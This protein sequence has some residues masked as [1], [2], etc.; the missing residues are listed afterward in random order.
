MPIALVDCNNF[1]VSCER[2][3]NPK[4]EG[5]PVVVLSNNDGCAVAR[6]NEVKALGIKMGEPWFRMKDIAKQ[7]GI[8]A[9][10]SNYT[11]YGDL[12]ARV[13]ATLA[14]FSPQQEV[15]SIDECFLDL[16]GFD[17]SALEDYGQTIRKTVKRN[18]GIP[19]CVGIADTKTLA[20][21][22]NHCAK[23]GLAGKNGVCD[24]GQLGTQQLSELFARIPA[25]DVWGVGR[26]TTATLATLNIN[27][28]EDLR[29]ANPEYL[30]Q[31]FS[32]VLMRTVNELNGVPCIELEEAGAARQ[33]IMVS[34]SFGAPVSAFDDLSESVAYYTTR[35]AEKLRRDASVAA[36]LCVFIHTNPFKENEEQY[37]RSVVVPLPQPTDD[38]S[39]LVTAA[40]SGLKSIYKP[41]LRY[42]KSG[43][44]LMGL[45]EKGAAQRTLFDDPA[46]QSR[47]D[48]MMYVMDAINQ[49]M[50]KDSVTVGAT[51]TKQRWA[52]RREQMSPNYTSDWN[53][54]MEAR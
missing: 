51:G 15:Y 54:L 10:S 2:M 33:Q 1:Y 47:S 53:E 30:R 24:F 41:N 43:V 35:A 29:S 49:R 34:R 46:E 36:S 32:V 12:S 8:I 42:K 22:A 25:G 31:Q 40:L 44:L 9:L 38:T 21:L 45:H 17:P 11:L 50:G 13:M 37:S 18:V 28:V 27:T 20:K 39:K 23:K 3:F 52:M 7:H 19:V 14:E 48:R 6:S 16:S 5:K 26:R 4:L